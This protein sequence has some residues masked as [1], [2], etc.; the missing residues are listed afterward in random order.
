MKTIFLKIYDM[1]ASF[2][3]KLSTREVYFDMPEDHYVNRLIMRI[4]PILY[5]DSLT[6]TEKVNELKHL[7][8]KYDFLEY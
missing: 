4:E 7:I 1:I 8:D 3:M 6:D 2:F 5:D